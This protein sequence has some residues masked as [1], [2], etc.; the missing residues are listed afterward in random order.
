MESEEENQS[1]TSEGSKYRQSPE[2]KKT[3]KYED[4]RNPNSTI[5]QTDLADVQMQ[6]FDESS[7]EGPQDAIV[8]NRYL[9]TDQLP[10]STARQSAQPSPTNQQTSSPPDA[11]YT[12]PRDPA[13]QEDT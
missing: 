9:A 5:P 7:P 8:G 1:T 12:L 3:R 2:K 11:Q 10:G 13:R 4:H 6:L